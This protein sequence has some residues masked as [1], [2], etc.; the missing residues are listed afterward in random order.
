M[1]D[2]RRRFKPWVVLLVFE[3]LYRRE[4]GIVRIRELK[5]RDCTVAM[6]D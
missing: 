3:A 6:V 4:T 1:Y 5:G 2:F